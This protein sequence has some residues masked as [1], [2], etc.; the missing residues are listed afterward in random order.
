MNNCIPFLP[1]GINNSCLQDL[2]EIRNVIP[3][4]FSTQFTSPLNAASLSAWKTNVQTNLSVYAPLG[5]NDFDPSTDKP[6]IAKMQST[7]KTITDRPIPSALFYLASNFCDY[8]D[9]LAAF[10]GGNFRLFFV[11]INGNFFGTKVNTGT[12]IG[13]VQGFAVQLTAVT[14][15]IPTKD[16]AQ[17]FPVYANFLVYEE[18]EQAVMITPNF[19]IT[20]ELTLAMPVGLTLYPTSNITA[21]SLTVKVL[22]RCGAGFTGL[23]AA[24]FEV[25]DSSELT[26]PTVATVTAISNGD[27]TLTITKGTSTPIAAGDMVVIRVNRKSSSITTYL[28]NRQTINAL[29]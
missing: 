10:Q 28:S 25:V 16:T 12:N 26:T 17:S 29:S 14:S 4:S 19:N 1:N 5:V 8:K 27:Y 18:F 21:G 23:L 2:K 20:Q 24:D 15:G 6:T 22:S 7:R 9:V 11:D 3:T 13:A